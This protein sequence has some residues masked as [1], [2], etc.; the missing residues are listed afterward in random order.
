M[1]DIRR[2]IAAAGRRLFVNDWFARLTVTLTVVMTLAFLARIAQKLVPFDVPWTIALAAG[3]GVAVLAAAAWALIARRKDLEI[4]QHVD[5]RAGL[6]E[7]LSTALVVAKSHDGWSENI[8]SNAGE[9]ARRVVVRDAVPIT[10]PRLWAVPFALLLA[11]AAV[12]W[13]PNYD[14]TGLFAQREQAVE[15]DRELQ[16]VRAEV[17]AAEDKIEALM[18]KAGMEVDDAGESAEPQD[19]LDPNAPVNP[20]EVR[21]EAIKK[22]TNL[23]EQL[24]EKINESEEAQALE[25]I[26]DAMRRLKAP[27]EGPGSEMAKQMAKGNYEQAKAELEKLAEQIASGEMSAEQKQQAADNLNAVKEQLEQMANQREQLEEQLQSAGYSAEQAAQMARDPEQ[28]QQQLEQN[29]EMSQ[30]QKQ[31]MQQA[32]QAQQQASDAMNSACQSMGQMAQ[33]LQDQSQAGQ[34]QASEGAQSMGQ[35]LS[36]MEMAQAEMQSAQAAMSEC[37]SQLAQ[38]GEGM[39]ENPGGQGQGQGQGMNRQWQAGM[40]NGMGSGSGGPGRGNGAGPQ[41]QA[42]DFIVRNEKANVNTGEGPVIASTLVYGSQI[43]GESK[44]AFSNVTSAAKAEAAEAIEHSRVP[45]RH[46][47]AVQHYFGRLEKAAE[48]GEKTDGSATDDAGN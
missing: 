24:D 8:V 9:R 30:Q 14:V 43:R 39:C 17:Q 19:E 46:E 20:E 44:V 29:Q 21:R 22:M 18:S 32:A 34:Q 10:A 2:V 28:M 1:E 48:S 47:A 26:N 27:T 6:R 7:S 12:W 13:V 15:Q 5:D 25:T 16:E 41:E 35:Q 45:R 31:Q 3:A 42:T 40:S 23:A 4:A 33:G 37:Q 11:L 36:Q 38:M